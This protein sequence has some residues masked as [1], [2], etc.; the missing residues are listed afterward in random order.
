M[1]SLLAAKA[2]EDRC[3]ANDEVEALTQALGS[4]SLSAYDNTANT[5]SPVRSNETVVLDTKK[6]LERNM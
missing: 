5:Y 2:R 3:G 6:F 1:L 4:A